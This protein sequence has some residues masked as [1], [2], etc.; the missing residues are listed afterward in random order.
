MQITMHHQAQNYPL[1]LENKNEYLNKLFKR[2]ITMINQSIPISLET[3]KAIKRAYTTS[4]VNLDSATTI[5]TSDSLTP[6]SGDLVVA[7][8]TSIGQHPRLELTDGRKSRLYTGDE[9][10]VCYAD[11]YAPDQFESHVPMDLGECHLVAGGGIASKMDSCHRKMKSP[12]TLQPIGLLADAQGNRMNLQNSRLHKPE[13]AVIN[14]PMILAVAGTAM[15][16]GKTTTAANLIKGC[17][18]ADLK[19]AA[20][21]ITGTGSGGDC[22]LMIDSGAK[23][24]LDFTN[25]GYAST[26]RLSQKTLEDILETLVAELVSH[27]PDV[28]ILEVADGIFQEETAT[29]LCSPVFKKLVDGVIFAA[30][31]SSGAFTGK[32]WLDKHNLP[33]KAIS[34]ALT[35]SPLAI[36]ETEKITS[37]PVFNMQELSSAK[38]AR[39]LIFD[40]CQLNQN[41]SA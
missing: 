21:K 30:A 3:L 5:L 12:T 32:L 27:Q 35:G 23:P 2:K 7:K 15:N 17:D 18:R 28:I 13:A 1:H 24:V 4:T 22:W 26:F 31:D 8:V 40:A 29:I 25:A 37:L 39:H 38:Y 41:V 14:R 36:R 20:A 16:A 10:L 11:R 33:L 34:G 19:V 9:V 6:N